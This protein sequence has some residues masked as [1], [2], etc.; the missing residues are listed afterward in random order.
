[1]KTQPCTFNT[2][3]TI[4]IF[5]KCIEAEIIS[6]WAVIF[7]LIS[8]YI[9]FFLLKAKFTSADLI[10]PITGKIQQIEL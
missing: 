8:K 10:F 1:M 5:R 4:S 6:F 9:D 2:A 7:I 3:K